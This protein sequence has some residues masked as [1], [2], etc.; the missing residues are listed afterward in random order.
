MSFVVPAFNEE[1]NL[2]GALAE[3]VAAAQ[4]TGVEFEA[5][6]IDDGSRD[7][8]YVIA[9][10]LAAADP[11]VVALTNGRNR[12]LGFTFGRG[13]ESATG[14]YVMLIPGDNE[15]RRDAIVPLLQGAT[16]VDLTLGYFPDQSERPLGRRV[17]SRLY[18]TVVNLAVGLRIRYYNGPSVIRRD[19]ALLGVGKSTSFAYMALHIMLAL[20]AGATYREIAIP[21]TVRREG[22]SAAMKW[23]NW[24]GV[25]SDL[26]R[27]MLH[28][29]AR[30]VGTRFR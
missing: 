6:L 13:V 27:F 29:T 1:A 8:T 25:I 2:N 23:R 26:T 12:G 16:S 20:D 30:R 19:L 3:I 15:V 10:Q 22:R 21:L 4:A 18:T 9:R 11:R 14:R 7:A 5:I 28:R 17:L 24:V